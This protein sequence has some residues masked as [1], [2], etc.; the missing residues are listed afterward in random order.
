MRNVSDALTP[1]VWQP[2]LTSGSYGRKCVIYHPVTGSTNT[3]CAALGTSGAEDGAL[4]I[5]EKQTAGRGRMDRSWFSP[6]GCGIWSSVLIRRDLPLTAAPQLSF[7][8][9]L[10]WTDTLESLCGIRAGLKWPNDV[11]LEG[12]KICGI[13]C[14]CTAAEDRLAYAVLGSGF[15]VLR[16]AY[17]PELRE[18]AIALEETVSPPPRAELL[19][20]YLRQL[21]S[22]VDCLE[23]DGFTALR[24]VLERRCV[25]LGKPVRIS[26]GQQLSGLATGLDD[27]GALL[28]QKEDGSTEAVLC[29]DVS[30]R[31]VMGYV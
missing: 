20:E 15:N 16:G 31:G 24:P 12:R 7:C 27:T 13:L 26:G 28:V 30:V 2:L 9:A 3:D 8:A 25:N 6:A 10:A 19:A 29:G 11:I 18:K 14:T 22:R 23:K 17:P 21:E 5:A 4:V 1:E